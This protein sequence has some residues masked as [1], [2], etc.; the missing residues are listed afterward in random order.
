MRGIEW[1]G[2]V[3]SALSVIA[4]AMIAGC[5]AGPAKP[6]RSYVE[7]KGE[8]ARISARD[9]YSRGNYIRAREKFM[10][11]LRIDRSIDNRGG[12]FADLIDI[13]RVNIL[14][15]EAEEAKTYLYDAV[16]AGVGLKDEKNLSEA[17]YTLANADEIT[18][19]FASALDSLDESIDIDRR[20]GVESG[21]R[22][23]LKARIFMDSG[24]GPEAAEILKRAV[25]LNR[26]G[27]DG[28]E[29]ANSLRAMAELSGAQ[30]KDDE[31]LGYYRDAYEIDKSHG[32]SRKIALD[33]ERMGDIRARNGG[34]K[35]AIALFERSYIVRLNG[36]QAAEA[37]ANLNRIIDAYVSMGDEKKAGFYL[38]IKTGIIEN[39][40][41]RKA[42]IR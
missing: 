32:D 24:R 36:N 10:E 30:G 2:P 1:K 34:L 42:W 29:T 25:Y 17:Y 7:K 40:V 26:A 31:A 41:D 35:D 16:R 11:S 14:L 6:E 15:G 18:G 39:S 5:A 28:V 4:A 21:A 12:E 9:E 3:R 19:D 27:R 22:L 20:L 38:K 37:V 13:G 8:E 23:N 33:L